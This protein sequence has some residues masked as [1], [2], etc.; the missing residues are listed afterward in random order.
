MYGHGKS[1]PSNLRSLIRIQKVH[2][3]PNC[4]P[5]WN[6]VLTFKFVG[7]FGA[8]LNW[9]W[10]T[11]SR[12]FWQYRWET[13]LNH[14]PFASGSPHGNLSLRTHSMD[15]L[16]KD[17]FCYSITVHEPSLSF[18]FSILCVC[19]NRGT[20]LRRSNRSSRDVKDNRSWWWDSIRVYYD[21]F[22]RFR[23]LLRYALWHDGWE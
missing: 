4:L 1:F 12:T 19:S 3:W 9:P 17:I 16:Q 6:L 5:K 10:S 7:T 22:Q 11:T 15:K 18:I 20:F 2:H 13:H 14:S 8:R 23:I 21:Q